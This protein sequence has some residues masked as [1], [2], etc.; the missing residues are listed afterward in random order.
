[1]GGIALGRGVTNSG[2]LLVMDEVI[3]DLVFDLPLVAVVMVMSC[4]VLVNVS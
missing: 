1:M 3:R 2:L 4:V